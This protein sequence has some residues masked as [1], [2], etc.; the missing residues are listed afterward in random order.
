MVSSCRKL[1]SKKEIGRNW[2]SNRV[3]EE[4]NKFSEHV[5]RADLLKSFKGKLDKIID[6]DDRWT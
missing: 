6:R 2:F 3:V 5:V 4:W 1:D